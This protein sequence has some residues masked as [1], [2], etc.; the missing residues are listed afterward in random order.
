MALTKQVY[1]VTQP[2]WTGGWGYRILKDGEVSIDQNHSPNSF[3]LKITTEARASTLAD[4][5]IMKQEGI[6]PETGTPA[7]ACVYPDEEV[8]INADPVG[9]DIHAMA[10]AAWHKENPS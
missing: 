5:I 9:A 6:L 7:I 8:A 10:L 3:S 1:Q 2:P 4:L